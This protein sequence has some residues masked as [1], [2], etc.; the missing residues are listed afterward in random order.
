MVIIKLTVGV[1]EVESQLVA[2]N[3][4]DGACDLVRWSIGRFDDSTEPC[5]DIAKFLAGTVKVTRI[6]S[7]ATIFEAKV[8]PAGQT[9]D[10]H[11]QESGI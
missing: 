7:M 8:R 10:S 6:R 3:F 1:I 4:E 11:E 5:F 9:Q 2:N